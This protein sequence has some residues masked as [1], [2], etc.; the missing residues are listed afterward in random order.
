MISFRE[1]WRLVL[2]WDLFV[3]GLPAPCSFMQLQKLPEER[4]QLEGTVSG[5]SMK[6]NFSR[7]LDGWEWQV[8]ELGG[9]YQHTHGGNVLA[10]CSI[11]F[12]VTSSSRTETGSTKTCRYLALETT[13][14]QS[15]FW[16][17]RT[18]G[19]IQRTRKTWWQLFP[20]SRAHTSGHTRHPHQRAKSSS[21][22][23]DDEKQ[24]QQYYMLNYIELRTDNNIYVNPR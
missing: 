9:V 2:F 19:T 6:L 22:N 17:E 20:S 12:T 18:T 1:I 3:Y 16:Q 5:S 7:T 13:T 8:W 23:N 11:N 24:Q 21:R 4:C 15:Q 14:T 10:S